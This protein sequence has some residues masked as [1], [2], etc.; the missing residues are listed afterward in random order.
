MIT[1]LCGNGMSMALHG[2]K[3]LAID[4]HRYLTGNL[5][6]TEMERS[7]ESAW[8]KNFGTRLRTGRFI[9]RLFGSAMLTN[10]LI[11]IGRR[12]P[13]IINWLIRK[14]HGKAF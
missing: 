5:S 14:T 13:F 7:Y 6:R 8:D 11:G 3:L 9:Q 4:V 12:F 2:S 10:S 1:P